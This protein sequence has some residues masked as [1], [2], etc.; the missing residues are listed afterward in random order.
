MG[1]TVNPSSETFGVS[2]PNHNSIIGVKEAPVRENN[3]FNL[4]DAP[5]TILSNSVGNDPFLEW[6]CSLDTGIDFEP[7]AFNYDVFSDAA[8]FLDGHLQNI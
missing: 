8:G 1:A 5:S 7:I 4:I 3:V 6:N 2:M